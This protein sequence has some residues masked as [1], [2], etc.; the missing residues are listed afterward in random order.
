MRQ[1]RML[2][3]IHAAAFYFAEISRDVHDIA[4]ALDVSKDAVYKWAKTS[5]WEDALKVFKYNGPR[6]FARKPSRDTQRDAGKVFEK[7]RDAY[8]KAIR[9]GVPLHKLATVA[10]DAVGL[11][12][13][14]IHAWAVQYGWR[15]GRKKGG[16]R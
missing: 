10:G 9:E 12:R 7:A 1:Q 2:V 3:K 13:R 15:D 4:E 11:P 8:F 5:E 14:R 16:S 6:G